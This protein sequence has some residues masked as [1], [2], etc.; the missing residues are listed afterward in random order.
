MYSNVMIVMEIR[1]DI[2]YSFTRPFWLVKSLDELVCMVEVALGRDFSSQIK[3]SKFRDI[4]KLGFKV[5]KGN[6]RC[7]I[8]G[9]YPSRVE[10]FKYGLVL[11]VERLRLKLFS[12]REIA[13]PMIE[14]SRAVIFRYH[15]I[16][17]I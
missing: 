11:L 12:S 7:I 13:N 3:S 10:N 2:K 14:I 17:R 16:V 1:N 6:V 4:L 9:K 15:G 5:S 8:V